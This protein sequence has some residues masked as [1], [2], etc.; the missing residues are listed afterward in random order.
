MNL[1][2]PN[3]VCGFLTLSLA[4][5]LLSL[6]ASA[7]AG[8][9]AVAANPAATKSAGP[10]VV[11]GPLVPTG[12]SSANVSA[13]MLN[14][15]DVYGAVLKNDCRFTV[16]FH[17]RVSGGQWY[18]YRLPPGHKAEIFF[19]L[20]HGNPWVEVRYDKDPG[21]RTILTTTRLKFHI[22]KARYGW[23]HAFKVLN[24]GREVVLYG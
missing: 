23:L 6:A 19:R 13:A 11:I 17:L 18:T 20:P 1:M 2:P 14:D 21:P 10:E 15:P 9:S 24:F 7:T 12:T 5:A 4:T 3:P 22:A 8:D 16:P